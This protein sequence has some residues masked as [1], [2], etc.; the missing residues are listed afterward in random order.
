MMTLR[1][2][3]AETRNRL[4]KAGNSNASVEARYLV[5]AFLKADYHH[6]LIQGEKPV[7]EEEAAP[8]WQAL[9][10]RCA[11]EPLQY[12]IGEWEFFGYPFL[13][14]EGVLIPRQDTE[15]LCEVAVRYLEGLQH[16]RVLDLCSGSGCVAVTLAKS[17]PAAEVVAVEKY[18]AAFSYLKKN[19]RRNQANVTAVQGD[20]FFPQQLDVS[21]P[22]DLIVSNPPYLTEQDMEHLQTEVQYE[23][24]T[25]LYGDKDG[26]LFYRKIPELWKS[27]LKPDGMIAFEIG[28]G[29]QQDVALFLQ[30]SGYGNVCT[31]QDLCGIIRVITAQKFSAVE[32]I[33]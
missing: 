30:Q 28:R 17:C 19:I 12:L 3:Y 23:P 24:A 10:K 27:F 33:R 8:L 14:G 5:E 1:Q 13:V 15:R 20:V 32:K 18:D 29:Q 9:E 6:L 7:A 21:G 22:F 31:Y 26:L 11:G 4:Q 25:A 2:I 16:P